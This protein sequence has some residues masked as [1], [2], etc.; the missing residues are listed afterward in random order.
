MQ[1]TTTVP[2]TIDLAIVGAGPHALTLTTHLLQK[3]QS[4][5]GK[6][7]VFDPSGR[8]MSRWKQ[9]FAA[10]EIP[11]L[12]SPAV[13]HPD[14]NPFALRK[15]AQSRPHEL[16]PPYDLPGTQLFEDFCQD[17]IRVWQ[18]QE[19]VI[20]LAV[21][22]IEP[23][24]NH[25]RPRFRLCLQDGQE[26]IARRVVLA[27]GSAQ[28]QIPD[29]VNQI[30]TAYPQDRLCHSQ[31]IDLRKLQ[32]MGKRVLIVGGGLTSGHLALGA[33]SRGAKVHLM[34]R[35]QLTEKLFDAEPGW[36][37]PK[38]LKDFFAQPD[39]EQRVMMIQQAR[40]GGSM[41]P[42]IATQLRQQ[43]RR[44]KIRIDEKCQVVKAEWL[45]ENWRVECSDGS[46]HECDYIWLSTGTKFDVTTEPLLKDILVAYPIKIVK[47]LPVLDT[48]LRWPGCELF[49]MGGLAALQVG[50]TARNLSGARM[51]CEKIVRAIVK[52]SV[53]LSHT[54][55]RV[56]AG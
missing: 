10:L 51:A 3:R 13:H 25:L 20:P 33:I 8:W 35:R 54:F 2:E 12:R 26:V 6:F 19:Q 14:P 34:I 9:Q 5:R 50:P 46:Q 28:I 43:V 47:G 22:S 30:Q 32:L 31:T 17:V 23:L 11:H 48:C 18:L 41:T 24:P 40:N 37:G 45:G 16:F 7:S 56:Q 27:T 49:I 21:K 39:W 55:N 15:F 53:A 36:L 1:F 29:W 4:I 52:P 44:G 42:A 38:Y